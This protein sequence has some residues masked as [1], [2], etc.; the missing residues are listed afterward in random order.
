[1]V[2]E[3]GA[4]GRTGASQMDIFTTF[5]GNLWSFS[6]YW[7]AQFVNFCSARSILGKWSE[8]LCKIRLYFGK[9]S[10]SELFGQVLACFKGDL[11][12]MFFCFFF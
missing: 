9:E 5:F 4:G 11:S 10:F 8:F 3:E 2:G 1:M 7:A 12:S 6:R